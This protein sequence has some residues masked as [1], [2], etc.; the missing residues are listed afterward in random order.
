MLVILA[1]PVKIFNQPVEL[2]DTNKVEVGIGEL[3]E[4]G[5]E[6]EVAG[7]EAEVTGAEAEVAG[8]EAKVVRAE[9]EVAG[10]EAKVVG[11]KAEVVM[12]VVKLDDVLTV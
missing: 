3:V 7:A 5:I 6:A 12:S 9:A 8:V 4:T 11:D 10:V 1:L 2:I